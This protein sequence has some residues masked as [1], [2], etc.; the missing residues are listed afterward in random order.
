MQRWESETE[1]LQQRAEDRFQSLNDEQQEVFNIIWHAL[2]EHSGLPLFMD[3]K[4]GTGK[5]TVINT[6][7]DAIRAAKK[8]ILP[9]ATSAFA[10]QLYT[11]G[12]TT[13]SMFKV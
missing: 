4:G 11:G 5:T 13:H 9:T 6:L 10:A 1:L 3:G 8:I 12:R 7:C 2:Q